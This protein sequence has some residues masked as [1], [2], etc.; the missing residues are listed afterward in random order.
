[1]AR[2]LLHTMLLAL[3]WASSVVHAGPLNRAHVPAEA[4]WLIHVDMEQMYA[5]PTIMFL[6]DMAL[7][8]AEVQQGLA[9][10]KE[11]LG[12]DPIHRFRS[13]TLFG[14]DYIEGQ[15]VVLVD[16]DVDRKK[17]E[18]KV[19]QQT[20]YRKMTYGNHALH[21]WTTN[22]R[23]RR[24][25]VKVDAKP[26][27]WVV[28]PAGLHVYA[29]NDALARKALDLLDKK[30]T[31]LGNQKGAMASAL[32]KRSIIF[33]EAVGLQNAKNNELKD[34]GA[35]AVV[36]SLYQDDAKLHIRGSV[37]AQEADKAE[38]IAT[39]LSALK[40]I[41]NAKLGDD[42]PETK[43]LKK[44]LADLTIESDG[45]RVAIVFAVAHDTVT[46]GVKKAIAEQLKAKQKLPD[47][48]DVQ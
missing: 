4:K 21:A 38:G 30:A 48:G 43:N 35:E 39:L 36:I 2:K 10:L 22:A 45:K 41:V 44:F 25:G 9:L 24:D 3:V 32:P 17:A 29:S 1:M 11:E 14:Y 23:V 6:R 47:L 28:H 33:I 7:K 16:A 8:Q 20:D 15:G 12:F 37:R 34:Y 13:M 19:V 18:A 46:R 26:V 40:I 27:V 31:P 42:D 5:N